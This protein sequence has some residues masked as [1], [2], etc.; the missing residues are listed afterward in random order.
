MATGL[1]DYQ[2]IRSKEY[3]RERL[4][5]QK[6]ISLI[7]WFCYWS[8]HL[9][10]TFIPRAPFSK[11]DGVTSWVIADPPPTHWLYWIWAVGIT[12]HQHETVSA[13]FLPPSTS[14]YNLYNSQ[15][16][17]MNGGVEKSRK[18]HKGGGKLQIVL[19]DWKQPVGLRYYDVLRIDEGKAYSGLQLEII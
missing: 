11:P 9:W 4:S 8:K 10:R 6:Y 5:F 2:M 16:P 17:H 13:H 15:S 19:F 12:Q 14:K 1:H 18:Q 7:L 3:H